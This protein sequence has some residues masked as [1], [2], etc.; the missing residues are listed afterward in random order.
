MLIYEAPVKLKEKAGWGC[1][2]SW[3]I[4]VPARTAYR[5]L[6]RSPAVAAQY[7]ASRETRHQ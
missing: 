5:S 1:D 7:A 6:L 2:S 4:K 3:I